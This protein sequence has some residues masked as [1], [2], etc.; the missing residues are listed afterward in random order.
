MHKKIQWITQTAM[1]LA[2]LIC[3]QWAGSMIS[4]PLVK[5]LITGTCVNCVLAIAVLY[6]GWSSGITIA[7][8]SPIFAFLL[9]IAPNFVTVLPI[10]IG[11]SCFVALLRGIAGKTGRPVWRQ[12]V[13][14]VAAASVKFG[15]L[16]ILVVKIVCGVAAED[17]LGKKVGSWVVLAA[18]M[19]NMLPTMFA[20]PQLV[21]ALTG[22]AIALLI[23]P[24]IRKIPTP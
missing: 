24:I 13:A 23:L 18:P 2:L 17:L 21:T 3:L 6:T 15:V 7:L 19:L 11:N 12:P 4:V 20:W 14:L 8:V 1:L 9:G 5:Q 16:Y 10:M 22:G